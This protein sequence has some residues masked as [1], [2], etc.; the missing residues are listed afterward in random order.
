MAESGNLFHTLPMPSR[1]IRLSYAALAMTFVA[2]VARTAPT[3]TQT[4]DWP[5]TG[6]ASG[7]SHYSPL[8]QIDRGNVSSLHVAWTYHSG[9][10]SA[11]NR[12]QIQATP[13]VVD[14]VMYTTT[15]SLDVIALRG[16]SGAQLWRFDP[17]AG[18]ARE[19]HVNRGVVYW[20]DGR[21]RRIFFSAGRRLYSLDA[22]TGRPVTSFG[23]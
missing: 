5:T 14:G 13:I 11:D 19:S 6:G 18:G 12:S 3:I 17:F 1:A 20:S 15:P 8:N 23:A 22:T 2:C 4:G 7:N 16:E 10:A 21:D 9:D